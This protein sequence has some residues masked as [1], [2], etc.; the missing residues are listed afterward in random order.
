MAT[1]AHT[2]SAFDE[3]LT[4]LERS[5]LQMAGLAETNLA[6]AVD[7]LMKRDAEAATEL[8]EADKRVDEYE[9]DVE[10][11]AFRL[12]ALRQPMA[13]DLR[14]V[15]GTVKMAGSLERIGDYAK[16]IAKRTLVL[17]EHPNIPVP[18]DM[19]RLAELVG[20]RLKEAIDAFANRDAGAAKAVWEQDQQVDD[21]YAR[22]M[23]DIISEM[24]GDA[25]AIECGAHFLFIGK[26]LERVGDHATNIAEVIEFQMSG[27]WRTGQRPKGEDVLDKPRA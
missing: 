12:L 22:V 5:V 24:S 20:E 8:I 19:A 1:A 16:N 25:E 9:R 2:V 27:A 10:A 17:A 14:Y 18:Q 15:F 4:A 6:L 26:N 21:Y 11:G 23:R 3:E 7:A 13:D